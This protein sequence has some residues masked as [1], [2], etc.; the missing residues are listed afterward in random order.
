[1][2]PEDRPRSSDLVVDQDAHSNEMSK[3]YDTEPDNKHASHIPPLGGMNQLEKNPPRDPAA[4]DYEQGDPEHEVQEGVRQ[5]EA[6]TQTWGKKSLAV[7][8]VR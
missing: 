7:V 5:M 3:D 4:L 2:N 6:I 1:M 8:Y